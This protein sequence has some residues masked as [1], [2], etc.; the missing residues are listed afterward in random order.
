MSV[1]VQR[2]RFI[3]KGKLALVTALWSLV[4]LY[5]GCSVKAD[6]KMF[7]F[8]NHLFCI[9]QMSLIVDR[10]N[11]LGYGSFGLTMFIYGFILV[12]TF[13]GINFKSEYK[14]INK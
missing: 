12:N 7:L 6:D 11:V 4:T 1:L 5:T 3:I 13:S 2:P 8:P 10:L 9:D 14:E